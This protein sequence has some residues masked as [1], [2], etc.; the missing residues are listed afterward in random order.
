M[1]GVLQFIWHYIDVSWQGCHLYCL[2]T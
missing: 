1:S 2:C